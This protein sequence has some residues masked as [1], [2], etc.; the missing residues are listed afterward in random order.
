MNLDRDSSTRGSLPKETSK[1]ASRASRSTKHRA[2]MCFN[3]TDAPARS[4]EGDEIGVEASEAISTRKVDQA[5]L[6]VLTLLAQ[7]R[8]R[9]E[10]RDKHKMNTVLRE[11]QTLNQNCLWKG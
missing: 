8:V 7:H 9:G 6:T 1:S 3:R 4:A 10:T 11:G 2:L 5:L